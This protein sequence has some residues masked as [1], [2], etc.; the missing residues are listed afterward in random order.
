MGEF[1]KTEFEI[2]GHNIDFEY[3]SERCLLRC[4]CGWTT[5]IASYPEPSV[6]VEVNARMR[7]HLA[8]FGIDELEETNDG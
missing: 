2:A 4:E 3:P 6:M 5:E 7:R 8:E 1:L